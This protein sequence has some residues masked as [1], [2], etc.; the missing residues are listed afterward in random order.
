MVDDPTPPTEI[1]ELEAPAGTPGDP[2]SEP[3]ADPP[4]EKPEDL[5]ARVEGMS[6]TVQKLS[7]VVN[8]L[9]RDKA[10]QEG[11]LNAIQQAKLDQAKEDL[12]KISSDLKMYADSSG[13]D[14]IATK[15]AR[16]VVALQEENREFRERL[17]RQGTKARDPD[18]VWDEVKGTYPHVDLRVLKSE[19]QKAVESAAKS[20]VVTSAEARF[21]NGT[22]SKDTFD[23]IVEA[24]AQDIYH[25]RVAALNQAKTPPTATGPAPTTANGRRSV[26]MNPAG[27]QAPVEVDDELEQIKKLSRE[28]DKDNG[29]RLLI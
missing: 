4:P 26:P 20:R 9:E 28:M 24:A 5:Q 25:P 7:Q 15:L 12:K 18:Q 19:W 13:D 10:K 27:N 16:S 11:E 8:H 23:G 14:D 3:P 29:G 2:P 1:E 22:M 21:K 17:E 6:K